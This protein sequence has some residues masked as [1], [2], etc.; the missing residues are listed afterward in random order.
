MTIHINK[1]MLDKDESFYFEKFAI[2][3]SEILVEQMPNDIVLLSA[4][5]HF[6]YEF[7]FDS[8]LTLQSLC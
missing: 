1:K 3:K 5:Y 8:L 6:A 2:E 7:L 4:L